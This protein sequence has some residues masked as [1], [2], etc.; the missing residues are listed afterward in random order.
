GIC[1]PSRMKRGSRSAQRRTSPSPWRTSSWTGRPHASARARPSGAE[2]SSSIS[3]A[4]GPSGSATAATAR[5]ARTWRPSARGRPTT[6]P[7]AD[8]PGSARAGRYAERMAL[9]VFAAA[10]A[11]LLTLGIVL[12]I[13]ISPWWW[14]LAAVGLALTVIAVVDFL[15]PR[16]SI[17][18]NFPLLGHARFLLE[19]V[20]PMIQQYFIERNWDGK[21]FDRDARALI[22][23][24]SEG[25]PSVKS[26]GTE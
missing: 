25:R 23:D 17:L 2:R 8:V 11:L 24:R 16:N 7:P 19:E 13:A 15:Q 9:L 4:T 21:P 26:F 18:R 10:P 5:T 22:Y 12:A 20:R 14:V 6:A 1:T 3:R